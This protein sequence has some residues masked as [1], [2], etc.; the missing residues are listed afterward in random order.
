M[1]DLSQAPMSGSRRFS[2]LV[3]ESTALE[4]YLDLQS[5]SRLNPTL[6]VNSPTRNRGG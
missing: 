5:G 3:E 6:I 2:P 1:V 4:A